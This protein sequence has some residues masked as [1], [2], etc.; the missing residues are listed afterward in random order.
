MVRVKRL[1]HEVQQ[2]MGSRLIIHQL[3]VFISGMRHF[4]TAGP[5][6]DHI[7]VCQIHKVL[8]VAAGQI[9]DGAG[10]VIEFLTDASQKNLRE[11]RVNGG[12]EPV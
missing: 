12:I 7:A 9:A 10:V 5:K 2:D 1:L 8:G 4:V 11:R 3:D 6:D